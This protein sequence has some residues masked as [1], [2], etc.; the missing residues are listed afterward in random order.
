MTI[1]TSFLALAALAAAF[2]AAPPAIAQDLPFPVEARQGQMKLMGLNLGTLVSMARGD[3]DYDAETAQ[4]AADNLV[5]LSSI[6]QR[7]SWPEGTDNMALIGTRALPEIWESRADFDE[8]YQALGAAA[9]GLAAAAGGGLDQ[10]RGALGP[11]G[12][13]CGACHDTYQAE[14]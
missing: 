9:G 8:K 4:A 10:M 11:V 7:F 5:A 13:A 3:A 14:D 12:A 6:D 1:R 2:S